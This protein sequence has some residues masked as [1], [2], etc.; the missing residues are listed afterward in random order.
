[1]KIA[2]VAINLVNTE[3]I[4]ETHN[5]GK[6][7]R[8]A[9]LQKIISDFKELTTTQKLN[10]AILD[11]LQNYTG[12]FQE[13]EVRE[14]LQI[15]NAFN[16]AIS[17]FI[18]EYKKITEKT[19]ALF[20]EDASAESSVVVATPALSQT[21]AVNSV[22]NTLKEI[23]KLGAPSLAMAS[24]L[25]LSI[26]SNQRPNFVDGLPSD[27]DSEEEIGLLLTDDESSSSDGEPPL[28]L[29]I[30]ASRLKIKKH[31]SDS[32]EKKTR[33]TLTPSMMLQQLN[34]QTLN[35]YHL[36]FLQKN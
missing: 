34:L 32:E 23:T 8:Q 28:R 2:D 19:Y 15:T 7:T 31:K 17:N 9:L 4:P 3:D 6:L 27:D 26:K 21:A 36:Y 20:A 33:L 18:T 10:N 30:P 14:Y 24:S 22:E 11:L 13:A 25:P 1:M 16:A 5:P 29:R 12:L 35:L